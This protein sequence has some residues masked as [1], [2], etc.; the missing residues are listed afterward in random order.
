VESQCFKPAPVGD[1]C[2]RRRVAAVDFCSHAS[3]SSVSGAAASAKAKSSLRDDGGF[4]EDSKKR[5]CKI[6]C[7][8]PGLG[9]MGFPQGGSFA[10]VVKLPP[11][12]SPPVRPSS[13]E[14][15]RRRCKVRFSSSP[16]VVPFWA[17]QPPFFVGY[18][19]DNSGMVIDGYGYMDDFLSV[20]GTCTRIEMGMERIFFST[21]G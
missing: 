8:P 14:L 18:R 7:A 13:S 2:A 21:H 12:S 11:A 4:H 16:T 3:P 20:C 19:D 9:S 10:D 6:G 1:V 15:V 5:L 17:H